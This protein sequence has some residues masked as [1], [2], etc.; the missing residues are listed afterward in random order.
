MTKTNKSIGGALQMQLYQHKIKRNQEPINKRK[1]NINKT[2]K[3]DTYL[4]NN[5]KCSMP[6][7]NKIEQ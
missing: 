1:G 7:V 3:T 2:E 6:L 4:Y 5:P